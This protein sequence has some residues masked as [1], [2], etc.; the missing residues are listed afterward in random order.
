[1]YIGILYDEFKL[2]VIALAEML[3]FSKLNKFD[4][5]CCVLRFVFTGQLIMTYCHV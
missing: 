2:G 4:Y 5:N 3:E 1:M